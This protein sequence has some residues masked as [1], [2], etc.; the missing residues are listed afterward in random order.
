M[1]QGEL[2]G[3]GPEVELIASA[4]A[5]VAEEDMLADVDGEAAFGTILRT[6]TAIDADARVSHSPGTAKASRRSETS[7]DESLPDGSGRSPLAKSPARNETPSNQT[8]ARGATYLGEVGDCKTLEVVDRILGSTDKGLLAGLD[9]GEYLTL[10]V[11]PLEGK[12]WLIVRFQET[13]GE[14]SFDLADFRITVP[15]KEEA[16]TAFAFSVHGGERFLFDAAKSAPLDLPEAEFT[17]EFC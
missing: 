4:A 5:A 9:K 6:V 16:I 14:V 11:N 7:D 12:S 15:G 10:T 17:H 2:G 13:E 8:A 1:V 3:C